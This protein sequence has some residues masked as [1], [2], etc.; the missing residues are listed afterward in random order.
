VSAFDPAGSSGAAGAVDVLLP[1]RDAAATLAD[2]LASVRDQTLRDF[3]CLVLDDGSADASADVAA[4]FAREDARFTLQRLPRRGLVATLNEGLARA[5]A[6]L[7]A[8]LD[9]DDVMLPARLERQV[10]FLRARPDVDVVASRVRFFGASISSG[11]AAYERWLN[12]TL[13]P[14]EIRRDLF[15]ESPLPHPSVTM[16][17]ASVVR[18][19]GYRDGVPDDYDLWLRLWRAGSRFAKLPDVLTR[20]RDHP[21]RLTRTDPR[22]TARALLSCKAEHL[23]AGLGLSGRDVVVWGAGRDGIRAAKALRR[24]GV[25]LRHLVDIAET[26]VGRSMLGVPVRAPESLE[27]GRRAFVVAAVGVKGARALIRSRLLAMGY[28]EGDGFV[29]FG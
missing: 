2:A 29:C 9:A 4:A 14:E 1:V 19:G 6:D 11:L 8:R 15:V 21:A 27:E 22:Y 12:A 3:R 26:K 23:V 25:V 18:A 10:A 24:R 20:L 16:R 28:R 17:R 5:R 7:V 13:E